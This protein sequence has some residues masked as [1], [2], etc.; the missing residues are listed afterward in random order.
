MIKKDPKNFKQD[1]TPGPG[2]YYNAST[3]SSFKSKAS[4]VTSRKTNASDIRNRRS[5]IPGIGSRSP[6]FTAERGSVSVIAGPGDYNIAG[7]I[8]KKVKRNIFEG[9]LI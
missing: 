1:A 2:Y 7:N 6:R 9:K 5:Q 3:A 4:S 8:L